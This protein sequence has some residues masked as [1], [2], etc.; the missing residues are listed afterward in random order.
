MKSDYTPALTETFLTKLREEVFGD[1]TVVGEATPNP[2]KESCL[3]VRQPDSNSSSDF[4]D[5]F[6]V[7]LVGRPSPSLPRLLMLSAGSL[8]IPS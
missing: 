8:F 1:C 3:F 5:Y 2:G 7:R 6:R 4:G